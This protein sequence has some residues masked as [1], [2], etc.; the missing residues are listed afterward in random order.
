MENNKIFEAKINEN[1][2][3]GVTDNYCEE[4]NDVSVDVTPDTCE[5]NGLSPKVITGVVGGIIGGIILIKKFGP[6][7][8][9]KLYEGRVK[10]FNK[11]GKDVINQADLDELY[12]KAAMWDHYQD[13]LDEEAEDEN[14]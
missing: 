1:E 9:A 12:Q 3:E 10:W 2:N 4:A 13:T 5:S 7:V 6:A 14:E 11:R 8:K